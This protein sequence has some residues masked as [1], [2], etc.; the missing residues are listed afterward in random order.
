MAASKNASAARK[1]VLDMLVE[2][3][4][5]TKKLFREFEKLSEDDAEER[6]S[7]VSLVCAELKLHTQL[8]EECFYPA[9]RGK[10]KEEDLLEEA[11]VEHASAKQLIEQLD[12]M[13]A[14]DPKFAATFTVLGEYVK[15]HIKEEENEMFE[16][17]QKAKVDWS[18]LMQQMTERR[19]ELEMELGLADDEVEGDDLGESSTVMAA[20]GDGET[21]GTDVGIDAGTEAATGNGGK[22]RGRQ[23]ETIE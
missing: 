3:H 6:E 4:K 10:L 2:D 12:A 13:D 7:L 23:R 21:A 14:E 15:H 22:G 1:E 19:M 16:Q 11:E 20:A 17:A 8:E 5:R 9:L 18:A